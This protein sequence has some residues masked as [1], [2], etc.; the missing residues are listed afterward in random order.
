MPPEGPLFQRDY[1]LR[2]VEQ[3]AQAIA[4][5]LGLVAQHKMQD[6][7]RALAEG[8][9][10]LGFD[11][12]LIGVLDAATFARQFGDDD[13]ISAAV[14]LLICDAQLCATRGDHARSDTRLRLASGLLSRLEMPNLTLQAE[15]DS[16]LERRSSV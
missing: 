4:R 8:Y 10:A 6:A 13:R 7:D 16:A 14:R 3:A 1:I 15:L 9:S 12:E 11:R 5:A 2:M